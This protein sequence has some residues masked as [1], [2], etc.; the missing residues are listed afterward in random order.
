MLKKVLKLNKEGSIG[1]GVPVK[2]AREL[3]LDSNSCVNIERV[4]NSLHI[5]KIKIE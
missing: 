3:D 5:T 1:I 4:G 2:L